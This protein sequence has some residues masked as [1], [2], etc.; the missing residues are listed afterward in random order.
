MGFRPSKQN[1]TTKINAKKRF[2]S[3]F[4]LLNSVAE[5]DKDIKA[6]GFKN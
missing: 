3:N 5:N 1:C 6:I 2:I 4:C